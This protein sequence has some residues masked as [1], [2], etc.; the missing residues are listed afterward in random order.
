MTPEELC[1]IE[2]IKRLKYA[3]ARCLDL[4][5]WDEIAGLFTED[6]VAAYSGGNYSFE[7]R[8]AIVDFLQRSM[9]AE[10]FHSSHKMHHPEIDLTGPT[11]ARGTW[12]L[13]DVVVMT[14]FELTIRGCSFYEDKYAKVAGTGR[15]A[16]PATDGCSKRSSPEATW[17]ACASPHPGGRP[18][19]R[20]SSRPD[21]HATL[22]DRN[23]RVG[24]RGHLLRGRRRRRRHGDARA[25]RGRFARR[26][27]PTAP[28]ARRTPGYR[29]VTWDTR[30]FGNSTFR[31]G[32]HGADASVADMAAVLDAVGSPR[33]M[34]S[35]SRWAVGGRQ[36]SRSRTPSACSRSRSPTRSGGSGPTPSSRTSLHSSRRSPTRSRV[37]A[38][39]PRSAPR[40]WNA[41]RARVPVRTTQH[42]PPAADA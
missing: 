19:A 32:T 33:A 35:G 41:I 39:T 36:P 23:R 2:D 5:R 13:D 12:A 24:R 28:G 1:E 29:V 7:G 3:Y 31:S 42:L 27:V 40:C 26:V 15:S 38:P 34:S 14:D 8:A 16:A 11:T 22:D 37:S 6:A 30:G 4:K 9:G 21:D 17:R 20:A 25:R 10:T 18:T